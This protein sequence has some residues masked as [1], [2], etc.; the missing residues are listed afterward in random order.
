[1]SFSEAG[2]VPKRN[3]EQQVEVSKK[4]C[5]NNR[6]GSRTT[7]NSLSKHM[8]H[9]G[10]DVY[11]YVN[12]FKGQTRVHMRVFSKDENSCLRPTK[13][14]V[15]LKLAVWSE[16]LRKMCHFEPCKDPDAVLSVMKDVCLFNHTVNYRCCVSLQ[17]LFQRKDLSF[18]LLPELVV[19]RYNQFNKLRYSHERI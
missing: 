14:G 7:L 15:S 8:V 16:L 9:L 18:Q 10:G 6:M 1:M 2:G 4:L 11:T 5:S 17:R 13:N 12:T 3:S 19:L